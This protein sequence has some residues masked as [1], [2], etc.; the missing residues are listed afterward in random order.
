MS[1]PRDTTE[2]S[3]NVIK[4]ANTLAANAAFIAAADLQIQEAVARG[5]FWVSTQTAS[6]INPETVFKH[7]ADLGY[8]VSFPDYPTNLSLQPAELFGSYWVNFWS[9]GGFIP[10][11]LKKPYRLLISWKTSNGFNQFP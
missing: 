4:D 2:A 8:G 10:S 6:D 9:N 5:V 3:T 7:Y 1:M 11:L